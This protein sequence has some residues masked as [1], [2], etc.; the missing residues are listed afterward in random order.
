MP[1]RAAPLAVLRLAVIAATLRALVACGSDD[2]TTSATDAGH[3]ATSDA[4]GRADASTSDATLLDA[5]RDAAS[6]GRTA[7]ASVPDAS[8]P[9][10]QP[11]GIAPDAIAPADGSAPDT[12]D[13]ASL[14]D[15][16][17]AADTSVFDAGGLSFRFVHLAPSAEAMDVC[18]N[19]SGGPSATIPFFRSQGFTGGVALGSIS[20]FFAFEPGTYDMTYLPATATTCTPPYYGF[21]GNISVNG[22]LTVALYQTQFL[23]VPGYNGAFFGA[24]ASAPIGAAY[25]RFHH[26]SNS[27]G[28]LDVYAS[29]NGDAASLWFPSLTFG[30]STNLRATPAGTVA[31]DAR[32]SGTLTTLLSAGPLPVSADV[33]YEAFVYAASSSTVPGFLWCTGE[34]PPQ[35]ALTRACQGP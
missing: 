31:F 22:P 19:K 2:A 12:S 15:A 24:S 9:D 3:D 26:A 13:G 7:D 1:T 20:A 16:A 30:A 23:P 10:A 4:G 14:A 25:V 21:N 18:I 5:A 33:S 29:V 11:D 17:D 32:A 34:P 8:S 35:G 6:D 27:A 28:A